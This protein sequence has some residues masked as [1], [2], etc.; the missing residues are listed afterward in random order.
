VWVDLEMTGLDPDVDRIMEIAVIVTDG[1]LSELYRG[2]EVIVSTPEESLSSMA[3]VVAEM[4][5]GSGLTEAAR[6]S[7]ITVAEAEER[8]LAF[9]RRHVPEPRVAPLAGNSIHVDRMFLRRLMPRLEGWFHYRNVDVSTIKELARR[10]AP[11]VV[12][13]APTKVGGHRAL[14][15]IEESIEELRYYRTALFREIERGEVPGQNAVGTA[16]PSGAN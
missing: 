12:A 9:V 3:P 6:L 5:A 16:E 13:D 11:E 1:S 15:D 7:D 10:W 4:H 14:T 8:A 2:P